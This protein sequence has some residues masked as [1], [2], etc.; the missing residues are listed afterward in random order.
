MDFRWISFFFFALA[1][2]LHIGFFVFES[3]I[4]QKTG[5]HNKLKISE[6]AHKAVKIWAFNQGFYNLFLAMGMFV[7]LGMI[8]KKQIF[9]AGAITSF[10]GFFMIAAGVVLWFSAPR[11]RKAA[12]LQMVPPLLGFL[13]LIS[14]IRGS[15]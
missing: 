13:F 12:V 9:I 11:L 4:L 3:I 1:A 5:A 8:F 14:H 15:L 2:I 7:G 6:E 10:A